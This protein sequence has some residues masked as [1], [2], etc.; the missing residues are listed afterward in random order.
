MTWLLSD[1]L[2][3]FGARCVVPGDVQ[4]R[5]L[6]LDSRCAGPGTAFLARRGARTDGHR[7][8]GSAVER[9][10]VAVIA[11]DQDAVPPQVAVPV[12]TM[13]LDSRSVARLG[14]RLHGEPLRRLVVHAITG[15]NGKT[16]TSAIL[17]HLL[18]A[19]G[20]RP[21]VVGTTGNHFEHLRE[22]SANTTPDGITL[23][24]FAARALAAGATSL[25]IEASS[26]GLDLGRLDGLVP[27]VVAF[28]NLSRDHLDFHGSM[29]AYEAAKT[30]LFTEHVERAR[31]AGKTPSAVFWGEDAASGRIAAALPAGT[32]IWW[33]TGSASPT[34]G[35]VSRATALALR[36]ATAWTLQGT[37]LQLAFD[38]EV[39]RHESPFVGGWQVANAA[40]ALAMALARHPGQRD[41]LGNALADFP[42]VPGRMEPALPGRPERPVFVDYAHTPDALRNALHTLAQAG[43]H[44]A[45][46]VIGC[47][48]DRD[49]SKRGP[50]GAAAA[51][52]ARHAFFSSDNPRSEDPSAIIADMLAGVPDGVRGR[53]AVEPDRT[54]A[55]ARAIALPTDIV[56][57]AGKGHEREQRI[58]GR[59]LHFDDAEEVRRIEAARLRSIPHDRCPLLA[60]WSPSRLATA[61]GGTLVRPGRRLLG[62]LQTD[63]RK[64]D[65]GAVFVALPGERSDGHAHAPS[66][67]AAGAGAIILQ[68]PVADLPSDVAVIR[69]AD[70]VAALGRL[71]RGILEEAR[72]RAGGLRVVGLTG[73]NGKTTTKELLHHLSRLPAHAT[74]GNWNNHLG[75]PLTVSRLGAGH[76]CAI[77]EMGANAPD[78]IVDLAAMAQPE[79]MVVTSIGE[80]HLE[81]FGGTL[82]H[83]RHAKSGFLRSATPDVV[84]LPASE[85]A[86]WQVRL[87]GHPAAVWT[88]GDAG[89]AADLT[90]SRPDPHGPITLRAGAWQAV[91][92]LP[93]PGPHN[94]SNLAAALLA[95]AAAHAGDGARVQDLPSL[96]L[97]AETL[98]RRLRELPALP[99]GR[100]RHLEIAGRMLI[101]DAYNANPDSMRASLALLAR[102]ATPRVAVLGPMRELGPAAV[103]LHTEVGAFAARAA[104]R[105]LVVGT[106]AEAH[107][108][109]DGAAAADTG[110]AVRR[111]ESV[112]SVARLLADVPPGATILLKASRSVRLELLIP[113]L[114]A[115]WREN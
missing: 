51:S 65:D 61:L 70:P 28:T 58:G 16:S 104:D 112:E 48:G 84:V 106:D 21:A 91:V 10:A 72:A 101:D 22:T 7:F 6:T 76:R 3:P 108:M 46:V 109:V 17:A 25:V 95:E 63:S 54:A 42:G 36:P 100:L 107:A 97:D 15:T 75:L 83:V 39:S 94:A 88:F 8:I 79:V 67:A 77:L 40:V 1:L 86:R 92:D 19:V 93:L 113:A 78:D 50:M 73:S 2:Q 12:W 27:D 87:Q 49:R 34:P 20:E 11:E 31:A 99:E 9:G 89:G 96:L 82:E 33:C 66:A 55:I 24:D 60:G 62:S 81:G 90:W 44:E 111:E 102:S 57:V 68:H 43:A 29:E 35:A 98:A 30:T 56:L 37:P 74:P 85:M 4:I 41:A 115:V 71:T 13:P 59:S 47:G 64:V 103:R 26:H 23:H 110:A 53:V 52:G 114:E 80:A 105:V 14:A 32:R 45:A 38:G 69:V 5:A 18:A